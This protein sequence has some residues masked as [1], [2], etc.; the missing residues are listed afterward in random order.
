MDGVHVH[1]VSA[2][3]QAMQNYAGQQISLYHTDHTHE[4]RGF[5]L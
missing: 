3:D 1:C 5:V 2:H 4:S